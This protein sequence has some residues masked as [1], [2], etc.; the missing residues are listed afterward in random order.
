[1]KTFEETLN[2]LLYGV[3]QWEQ[4]DG[5]CR[6]LSESGKPWYVYTV[7]CGVPDAPLTG[8]ELVRT[9]TEITAL[10]RREHEEDYLGIAYADDLVNPSLVK[11][12]DPNNLGSSCGSAGYSIPPGWVLSLQAPLPVFNDV[13]LP[14]NRQRW[15]QNLF[16]STN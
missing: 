10:L 4:W 1:M 2:G 16:P 5:L 7:G 3:M 15:W 11:I 8:A 13:V 6:R 14:G 9:L 12:Y